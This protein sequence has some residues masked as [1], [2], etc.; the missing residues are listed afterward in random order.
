MATILVYPS[1][2]TLVLFCL[3]FLVSL[4]PLAA[5]TKHALTARDPASDH[6][7]SSRRNHGPRVNPILVHKVL[8]HMRALALIHNTT[9]P[10]LAEL[11]LAA[12]HRQ[13]LGLPA[14]LFPAVALDQ[15]IPHIFFE[16]HKH[17]ANHANRVSSMLP[18]Q[19]GEP[20]SFVHAECIVL[21]SYLVRLRES[22]NSVVVVPTVAR[23]T[24]L[25]IHQKMTR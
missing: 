18:P 17:F 20:A 13:P 5:T 14:L 12:S 24:P 4:T 2:A 25:C 1:L 11:F 15:Q 3:Y 23:P 16:S 9:A 21:V 8:L 6:Q 10:A 7:I 22:P 19:S